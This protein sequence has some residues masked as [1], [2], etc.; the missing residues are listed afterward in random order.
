MHAIIMGAGPAGL[1]AALALHQQ[2]TDSAPFQ[3]TV[4]ELRAG[5]QTIGGAVNL[6]PLAMRYLDALGVGPRLR[7]LGA[8]VSYIEMLSHR[9]GSS[10]GRLWPDVD[11]IRV[12]R[13][14]LVEAMLQTARAVPG[15]QLRLRFGAKV[16]S[17]EELGDASGEGS[18]KVSFTDTA[19]GREETIQGDFIIGCDGIHSF[20][21]S[22]LVDPTRQKT[23][24]GRATAYGFVTVS[25]PGNAGITAADGSPAVNISTL[26]SGQLGSLL[27]TFFEPSLKKLYL[28][29]VIAQPEKQDWRDGKRAT[30]EDKEA[31]QRDFLRRF[32]GGKLAG[33]EDAVR[34]CEEWVS[35]PVYMLPP[36]GVWSKG[37]AL[38]LGDAAHAMPPQGESTGIAIEDGMLLARVFSRRD[39]R[40]IS[41]M[42]ADYEALRRPVIKKAYDEATFRWEKVG[43]RSWFGMVLMEWLTVTYIWSMN[44]WSKNSFGRDVRTLDLPV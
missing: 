42:L 13:Q 20:V 8:K 19:S 2:S 3:V 35:F 12:L 6:T 1:A 39:T 21:R 26:V 28:A 44:Y 17:I 9:T 15:D 32:R 4:L 37:R 41:Q 38:L 5:V 23:Y 34:R 11:A 30:G 29:N 36:G 10:L 43:E 22:S 25:Q 33:L 27:L 18:V 24:S 16:A 31:L 14:D 40:S 7:P